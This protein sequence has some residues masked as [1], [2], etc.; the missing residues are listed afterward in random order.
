[1]GWID[2]AVAAV[3]PAFTLAVLLTFR[4]S[5]RRAARIRIEPTDV[6]TSRIVVG[7]DDKIWIVRD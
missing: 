4:A 1:M 7:P 3:W 2:L 6:R 5:V